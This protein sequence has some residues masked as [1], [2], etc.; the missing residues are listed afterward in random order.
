MPAPIQNAFLHDWP[1]VR[2]HYSTI[3]SNEMPDEEFDAASFSARSLFAL[4]FGYNTNFES[5]TNKLNALLAS[6]KGLKHL[7]INSDIEFTP[8]YGKLPAISSLTLMSECWP[9]QSDAIPS[10]WDFSRLTSLS[11]QNTNVRSFV[12]SV[13]LHMLGALR[14]LSVR[15]EE[16]DSL[17]DAKSAS[18]ALGELIAKLEGLQAVRMETGFPSKSINAL[19]KHGSTLRLLKISTAERGDESLKPNHVE[20]LLVSCPHLVRLSLDFNLPIYPGP[21]DNVHTHEMVRSS[22]AIEASLI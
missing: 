15:D 16:F 9:Y 11:F 6:S 8:A 3:Y 1:N 21:G 17:D 2:L 12:D 4:D 13:P 18:D 22:H 10:I 20:T 14:D 5:G 19:T 7:T